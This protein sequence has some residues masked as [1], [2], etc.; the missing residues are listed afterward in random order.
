MS[1]TA[2]TADTTADTTAAT[3]AVEERVEDRLT[4]DTITMTLPTLDLN[5]FSIQSHLVDNVQGLLKGTQSADCDPGE[6]DC[7]AGPKTLA[8]LQ[9][10][11][12]AVGLET[13]GI[14]GPQTWRALIEF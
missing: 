14:V 5:D 2:D 13:D 1:D 9:A 12:G 4:D 3:E 10:F 6:I 7:A 11:Q 8:A